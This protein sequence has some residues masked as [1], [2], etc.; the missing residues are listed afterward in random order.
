MPLCINTVMPAG[1]PC[2]LT[3]GHHGLCRDSLGMKMLFPDPRLR[4]PT[5]VAGKAD[6]CAFVKT[7]RLE[8]VWHPQKDL[9]I[10]RIF[11]W[12]DASFQQDKFHNRGAIRP[13]RANFMNDWKECNETFD[14]LALM[15]ASNDR[16]LGH[17]EH[18]DQKADLATQL[19][20]KLTERERW[21]EGHSPEARMPPPPLLASELVVKLIDFISSTEQMVSQRAP[22]IVLS[23]AIVATRHE[24]LKFT[25]SINQ[26]VIIELRGI[27]KSDVT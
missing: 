12:P 13:M 14:V 27:T 6:M 8:E 21:M 1:K 16:T 15:R 22:G 26:D 10:Q 25:A 20:A 11:V 4:S 5:A 17:V 2:V 7:L 19:M 3:Q 18:G 24:M 9:A 23:P